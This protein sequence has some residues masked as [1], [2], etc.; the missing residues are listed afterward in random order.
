MNLKERI[1]RLE[2][3]IEQHLRESGTIQTNLKWNTG[4]TVGIAVAVIGRL[5]FE[6]LFHR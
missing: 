1:A 6:F 4:I 5:M 3:I 2:N